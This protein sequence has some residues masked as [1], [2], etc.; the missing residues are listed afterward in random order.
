VPACPLC[1]WRERCRAAWLERDH[2]TQV[3]DSRRSQ[4]AKLRTS[5]IDTVAALAAQDDA[6]RVPGMADGTFARLRTQA[7]LQVRGR[8]TGAPVHQL[9]DTA[10][11]KDLAPDDD[12]AAHSAEQSERE[13][14]RDAIVAAI[15]T[16]ATHAE[17]QVFFE[18]AD[19]GD[20]HR[21][22]GDAHGRACKRLP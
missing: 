21:L 15:Q 10:W 5:G 12:A 19:P 1:P 14:E 9:L 4:I 16:N 20:P 13:A 17:A 3:A 22:D 6:T 8:E 2:L 7:A 11:A 18:Q